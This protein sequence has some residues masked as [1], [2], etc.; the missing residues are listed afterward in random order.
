MQKE[1]AEE[2]SLLLLNTATEMTELLSRI[3]KQGSEYE[4]NKYS[5]SFNSIM[6]LMYVEVL[7]PIYH[8]YPDLKP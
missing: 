8:E 3:H 7:S 2:I 1:L 4:F 5:E 6:G